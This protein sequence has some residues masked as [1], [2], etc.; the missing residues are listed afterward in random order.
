M[1]AFFSR[2]VSAILA[3]LL[4]FSNLFTIN[5]HLMCQR[6][7][8]VGTRI[9]TNI[10]TANSRTYRFPIHLNNRNGILLCSNCP[11]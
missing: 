5:Q 4:F 8:A 10:S 7:A 6:I 3:A 1:E 11:C 2:F 9:P